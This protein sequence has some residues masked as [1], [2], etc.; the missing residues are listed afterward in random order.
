MTPEEFDI[1]TIFIV[2]VNELGRIRLSSIE[3]K[4]ISQELL[5]FMNEEEKIITVEEFI[6]IWL[7]AFVSIIKGFYHQVKL[8]R[9]LKLDLPERWREFLDFLGSFKISKLCYIQIF[10]EIIPCLFII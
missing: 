6:V 3:I 10:R 5:L 2:S 9:L 8:I 4:E 7:V 1:L